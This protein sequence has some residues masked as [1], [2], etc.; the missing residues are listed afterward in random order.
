MTRISYF[1]LPICSVLFLFSAFYK[2]TIPSPIDLSIVAGALVCLCLIPW[3]RDFEGLNQ[4]LVILI[5]LLDLYLA[6][7]LIP[8]MPPWGVKKLSAA[9][10]FGT[11]AFCAGFIINRNS[12]LRAALLWTFATLSVPFAAIVVIGSI[13]SPLDF[14]TIGG[15]GYQ[16]TGL[17]FAFAMIASALLANPYT[18]AASVLGAMVCGNVTGIAFGGIAV[19]IVWWRQRKLYEIAKQMAWA[20]SAL[21]LYTALIAPP[22]AIRRTLLTS[23]GI[24]QRTEI[25]E[26]PQTRAEIPEFFKSITTNPDKLEENATTSTERLDIWK[27]AIKKIEQRPFLGW[28]YGNLKYLE[29]TMAHNVFLEMLAEG[30]V[31]AFGLMLAIFVVAF[32]QVWQSNDSLALGFLVLVSLDLMISAIWGLRISLFAFGLAAAAACHKTKSPQPDT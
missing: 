7:R 28:G 2:T 25:V 5:V 3:W 22:L 11:P 31:I 27:F 9:I 17:F 30:G 4:T 18:M 14:S 20:L 32:R 6:I 10:A 13:P 23:L 8:T 21:V 16:I 12:N 26:R 19:G 1:A 29:A 24:A 15:S